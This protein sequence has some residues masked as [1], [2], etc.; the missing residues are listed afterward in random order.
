MIQKKVERERHSLGILGEKWEKGL[1]EIW[2]PNLDLK[3]K[4][5]KKKMTYEGKIR[6]EDFME[7]DFY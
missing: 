7:N 1:T 6:S 4:K 3:C 5:K 2:K